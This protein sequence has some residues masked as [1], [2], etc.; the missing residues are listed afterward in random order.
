MRTR[1]DMPASVFIDR[2]EREGIPKAGIETKAWSDKNV[3]QNA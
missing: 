3:W 1:R 2:S